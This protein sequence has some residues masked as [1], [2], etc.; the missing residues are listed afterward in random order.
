MDATDIHRKI[1]WKETGFG[2]LHK[3]TIIRRRYPPTEPVWNTGRNS[4]DQ[5]MCYKCREY[6]NH[7]ARDC[8][9]T[10]DNKGSRRGQTSGSNVDDTT[11][12]EVDDEAIITE[13]Q[14]A[15]NSRI[16]KN[17]MKKRSI[18]SGEILTCKSTSPP[19]PDP[20]APPIEF[21]DSSPQ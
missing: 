9:G 8:P 7:L 4:A 2:E 20:K 14:E 3:Y 18:T 21:T 17:A 15:R 5:I 6:G 13:R 10:K 12:S 19:N 16:L 1:V 11:A